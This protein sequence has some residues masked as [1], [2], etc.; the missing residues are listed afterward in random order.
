MTWTMPWLGLPIPWNVIPFSLHPRVSSAIR[1]LAWGSRIPIFAGGD[2]VVD[3]D[4]AAGRDLQAARPE[5]REG[6]GGGDL[7]DQLEVDV[8]HARAIGLGE[9]DVLVPD[10]LKE[11]LRHRAVL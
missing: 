2:D 8:E 11:G 9:D 5:P 10:L 3:V 6:L 7:V 4:R 1:F